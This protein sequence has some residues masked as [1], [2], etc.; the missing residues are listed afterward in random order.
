MDTP[1]RSG[2]K[3]LL[4]LVGGIAALLFGA[5]AMWDG[6]RQMRG[7]ALPSHDEAKAIATSAIAELAEHSDTKFGFAMAVPR[8]WTVESGGTGAHF[9][10]FKT[11]AGIVNVSVGAEAVGAGETLDS[12]VQL[13]L[14]AMSKAGSDELSRPKLLDR[15]N[16]TLGRQQAQLLRMSIAAPG[17]GTPVE[18]LQWHALHGGKD[19]VI[20]ICVP[21]ELSGDFAELFARLVGSVRFL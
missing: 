6:V 18:A 2:L 8:S 16:A 17:V 21:S 11:L 3:K 20:T 13:T 7:T 4:L 1:P 12:H 14:D 15:S 19:Y 10:K 5:Y 9:L